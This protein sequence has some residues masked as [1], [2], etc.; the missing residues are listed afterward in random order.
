M[1]L[2]N[3]KGKIL[4]ISENVYTFVPILTLNRQE[5]GLIQVVT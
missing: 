2:F 1:M 5:N 3:F 4:I